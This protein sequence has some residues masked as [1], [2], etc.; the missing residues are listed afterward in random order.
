[1]S[2]KMSKL[3]F[4]GTQFTHL[5]LVLRKGFSYNNQLTKDTTVVPWEFHQKSRCCVLYLFMVILAYVCVCI[6]LKHTL[7]TVFLS[8]DYNIS[9]LWVLS[10]LH[11]FRCVELPHLFLELF[12]MDFFM[13]SWEGLEEVDYVVIWTTVLRGLLLR[14]AF[15]LINLPQLI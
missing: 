15:P 9:L 13:R 3:S 2:F 11:P 14:Y 12:D 4:R 10:V 7:F 8:S 5:Y 6:E 1:M